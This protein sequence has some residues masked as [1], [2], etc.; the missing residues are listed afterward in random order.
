MSAYFFIKGEI[1][2]GA[3][4]VIYHYVSMLRNPIEG[5]VREFENLTKA[6]ASIVRIDQTIHSKFRDLDEGDAFP[7]DIEGGVSLEFDN[8]TLCYGEDTKA[9]D[10]ISFTL[11]KGQ[12]LGLI[13]ETGSGKS[14]IAR[15]IFRFYEPTS[16]QILLSG[17]PIE[18]IALRQL[19]GQMIFASQEAEI[20]E[21]TVFDNVTLFD[22][23]YSHEQVRSEIERVG[24]GSWLDGLPNGLDTMLGQGAVGLSAG[25]RQMLSMTR[26]FLKDSSLVILDEPTA[27]L[28]PVTEEMFTRSLQDLLLNRTAIVIAHRLKTLNLIDQIAVLNR[29]KLVEYGPRVELEKNVHSRYTKSLTSPKG[30]IES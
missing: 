5:F 2:L 18:T 23:T 4:Y 1:T 21:A 11:E 24:L 16:G 17:K 25:Q 14:S 22:D 12:S 28:D 9:L 8:V 19:R 30:G 29:G 20:F 27:D 3:V 7:I 13:G 26:A 15:L 10:S 6:D